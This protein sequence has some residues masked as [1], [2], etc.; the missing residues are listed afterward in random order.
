ML[1]RR[2]AALISSSKDLL[3]ELGFRVPRGSAAALGARGM[4]KGFKGIAKTLPSHI[5]TDELSVSIL[6]ALSLEEATTSFLL[7]KTGASTPSL[8]E[9]LSLLELEGLIQVDSGLVKLV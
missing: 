2:G 3:E 7:E 1:I 6:G 8:N 9:R 5:A 4:F